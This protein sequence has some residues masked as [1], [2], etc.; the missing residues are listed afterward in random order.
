MTEAE[1]RAAVVAEARSWVGTPYADGQ[2]VKGVGVDCGLLLIGVYATVG[3]IDDFRPDY[4]A[5]QHHLHSGDE[6]YLRY[7]LDRSREVKDPGDGDVVMFRFGR[8]FSHG[9]I[10]VGW[11]RIVH[12]MR[13]EGVTIDNV[14]RCN[15]GPRALGNLPRRF[16]TLWS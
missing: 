7:V 1:A 16:F 6:V 3:L 8:V 15:L 13:L 11:P 14:E 4:Y 10:V 9:G 5:P 12:S 2:R